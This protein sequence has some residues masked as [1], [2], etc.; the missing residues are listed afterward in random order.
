MHALLREVLV[1]EAHAE[2]AGV[3]VL[4]RHPFVKAWPAARN[5]ALWFLASLQERG[6]AAFPRR[7]EFDLPAVGG[8]PAG[9]ADLVIWEPDRQLPSNIHLLDFK[10]AADF[11]PEA[12][13]EHQAQLA[14]YRA[15]LEIL[16]PGVQVH[17]W[18]ISLEGKRWVNPWE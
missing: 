8:A 18:L 2:G 14:D 6:L 5:L 13:A 17:S 3:A 11:S 10:L 12:L 16:H 15:A 4:D 7:S 9:R 1:R